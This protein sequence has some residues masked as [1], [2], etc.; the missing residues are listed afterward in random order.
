MV[1]KWLL[2]KII[3]TLT[4]MSLEFN[5]YGES[6]ETENNIIDEINAN[7]RL[8]SNEKLTS[9]KTLNANEA[10]NNNEKL[11]QNEQASQSEINSSKE[12]ENKSNTTE[13]NQK[14]INK[15]II[16]G[17]TLN[18][19]AVRAKIPYREKEIFDTLKTKKLI[20]NL[21]SMGYFNNVEVQI[22][23]ASPNSV[24]LYIVLSQ[25][26][27]VE[28][29]SYKGNDHISTSDIEKKL[30][31]SQVPAMDEDDLKHYANQIK[32]LYSEK[33]FHSAVI[34]TKLEPTER[35]TVKAIFNITE[36]KPSVVK[37]VNFIGNKAFASKKLRNLLFT[38][39]DWILGFMDK[40]GSFQPEA[41]E[42]D[43]MQIENFYQSNGYLAARVK[44]IQVDRDPEVPEI[45][46]VTY[47][48]EEGDLY[49]VN[50]ISV[51]GNELIKEDALIASIPIRSGQLYSRELI[52]KSIES[53]RLIWGQFGYIYA[54]IDP[55]IQPNYEKKT[56]DITLHSELGS[57]V[58]L[59]RL[60]IVGNKK[61]KDYV[62]RRVI[63]LNEGDILTTQGMEQSKAAVESLGFFDPRAGVNWR[64]NKVD[65]NTADLELILQEAKTGKIYGQVGFGGADRDPKSPA[66]SLKVSAGVGDRN[67]LGTGIY[68]NLAVTYAKEDRGLLFSLGNSWLFDRPI[69]G[70]IEAYHRRTTY[71]EFKNLE[72]VPVEIIT[73]GS[74]IS[75]FSPY[76]YINT[77]ILFNSGIERI[78]YPNNVRVLSGGKSEPE[79][80][81]MQDRLSRQFQPG[82][83]SWVGGSI[84]QD[85]RN[86]P[87]HANRGYQWSVNT[88]AGLPVHS[89]FGFVKFEGDGTWITPIIGEYDL[90][91]ILHG[92]AGFIKAAPGKVIPYREL[93]HL[94]GPATVRGF[95][96][97][98]IGPNLFGDSLGG[99]KA[100]WVN[101]ELIFNVTKDFSIKGVLFYDGGA[102]WDTP[103]VNPLFANH[104]KNNRFRY[105]HA[106]G[107]GV[108]LTNPAPMKIDWGFKLD[109]NKKRGES[110]SEVHFTMAQ[111]F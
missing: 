68:Y 54:D 16:E 32:N 84:G 107:F 98:Q 7:E 52:R 50:S 4:L 106:I 19:S 45:V 28:D 111:E 81:A 92:H 72:N 55:M 63:S 58:F 104:L 89:N 97:G 41:L 3:I 57:K 59:N 61:T 44:N 77:R 42:Y 11:N 99:T 26:K 69:T 85:Y 100:F 87:V 80:L 88:K 37:R 62:I 9:T 79:R 5:A 39:E 66:S 108:R 90:I 30:K 48:I 12:T 8:N 31:L 102:S 24:N 56:V 38:R 74:L 75:G 101:A 20:D 18:E 35:D 23:D 110:L 47:E 1:N 103:D 2:K 21:M 27:K 96:F 14:I 25:K 86:S 95:N 71:E 40:A 109:R 46:N 53:L 70:A 22:E 94:G 64:I 67:L 51:P 6:V 60:I 83:F 33:N 93:F 73:G 34:E 17:S 78:R 105:R 36:G 15:I 91:F 65:E 82:T 13:I 10:L 43:K 49:T 29:I 76:G